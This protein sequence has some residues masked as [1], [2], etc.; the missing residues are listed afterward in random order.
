MISLCG[1]FLYL[2]SVYRTKPKKGDW[3]GVYVRLCV[4]CMYVTYHSFFRRHLAD[5]PNDRKRLWQIQKGLFLLMSTFEFY[6]LLPSNSIVCI[7]LWWW[8]LLLAR[9]FFVVFV[10]VVCVKS[11]VR[12]IHNIKHWC[13]QWIYDIVPNELTTLEPNLSIGT[14]IKTLFRL[15]WYA[16]CNAEKIAFAAI[17]T[18]FYLPFIY[19]P[20]NEEKKGA[21]TK[22]KSNAIAKFYRMN[23]SYIFIF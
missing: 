21:K 19:R 20:Q 17:D 11:T 23:L 7:V 22:Q 18:I 8:L 9:W 2:F 1:Y 4:M 16:L 12:M 15:F 5:I 10:K 3:I 14:P 6:F 13:S